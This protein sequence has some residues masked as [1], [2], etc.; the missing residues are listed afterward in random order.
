MM[1]L[2]KADKLSDTQFLQVKHQVN[3]SQNTAKVYLSPVIA[4]VLLSFTNAY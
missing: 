4:N 1:L 2:G 3:N